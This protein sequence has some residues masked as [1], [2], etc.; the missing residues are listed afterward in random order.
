MDN[1]VFGLWKDGKIDAEIAR[2]NI[3]NRVLKQKI[4]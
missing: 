1:V 3:N 2:M 4:T